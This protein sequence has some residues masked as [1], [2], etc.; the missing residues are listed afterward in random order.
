MSNQKVDKHSMLPVGTILDNRY[1]IDR[2]LSSGGFGN[3]YVATTVVFKEQFAIKEFFMRG[4]TERNQGDASVYVSN[5]ENQEQ[6]N[7]QLKAFER[8]AIKLRQLTH[9]DNPHIVKVHDFIQQ[10]G[11][12]YFVMDFI[13]GKSLAEHLKMRNTPFESDWL[14]DDLLPQLLEALEVVHQQ[15]IWHLDIKPSNIL[16]DASDNAI[17]IDFGSSKQIDPTTGDPTTIASMLQMT[18]PYAPSELKECDYGKIGPWTDLYSLGA[19]LYNLATGK[20]PPKTTEITND[21]INAFKFTAD[22][23]DDFKNLVVWLMKPKISLRPQNVK[24]VKNAI[25]SGTIP[26][27]QAVF[28]PEDDH[29]QM[30]EVQ[31]EDNPDDGNKFVKFIDDKNNG[32]KTK[33]QAQDNPVPGPKPNPHKSTLY[34][35]LAFIG[36]ALLTALVMSLYHNRESGDKEP[37]VAPG[38][39]IMVKDFVYTCNFNDSAITFKYTGPMVNNVPNGVGKGVFDEGIYEG[40]FVDGVRE[41]DSCKFTYTAKNSYQGDVYEGGYK[42]GRFEGECIYTQ[43]DG[44]YFKGTAK[45]GDWYNGDWYNKKGEHISRVVNGQEIM[46]SKD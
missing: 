35:F 40:N 17:L 3:T 19:T 11:T 4:I 8:E 31:I 28:P 12:S 43:N 6:F 37:D 29:T 1:R 36:A 14:M 15:K 34:A 32:L 13:D 41:G 7:K 16:L 33:K 5:S 46:D 10:N 2:Q 9:K 21:G 24:E 23:R 44:F 20:T 30:I 22:I 25:T 27:P 42:N 26:E 39:I 38:D 45:N 18:P